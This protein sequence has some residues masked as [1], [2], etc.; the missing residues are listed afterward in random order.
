MH[1]WCCRVIYYISWMSLRGNRWSKTT[2]HIPLIEVKHKIVHFLIIHRLFTYV[3]CGVLR[4][5]WRKSITNHEHIPTEFVELNSC[6]F[7]PPKELLYTEITIII[8]MSNR[9]KWIPAE[10]E[11]EAAVISWLPLLPECQ[12]FNN[13]TLCVCICCCFSG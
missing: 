1:I 13:V 4:R 11:D 3:D 10:A 5:S 6:W 7:I 2:P 8:N 12:I 9:Q